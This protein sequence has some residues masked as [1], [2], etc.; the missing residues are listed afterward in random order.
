MSI[1]ELEQRLR[2]AQERARKNSGTI[3]ERLAALDAVSDAQRDLAAAKGLPFARPLDIGVFP[4]AGVSEA[5]LVQDEYR[6]VL[7]FSAMRLQPDGRRTDAGTATVEFVRCMATRFGY[8]NDEAL[9]GHPLYNSGL[10]AYDVFEVIGSPWIR[11]LTEQNRVAFPSTP[12]S[13]Q[14]HFI[15]TFHDSTFE[16]IADDLRVSIEPLSDA[17]D[18]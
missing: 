14:R 3:Q 15:F 4:E 12:D 11:R 8:P 1:E 2:L 9:R 5:R 6:A 18:A 16:C 17:N 7:T 10:S 13:T